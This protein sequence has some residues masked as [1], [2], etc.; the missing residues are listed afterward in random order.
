MPAP[1]FTVFTPTY[2]RRHTLPRVFAALRAQT[3]KD[4][5]WLVVDDGSQDGSA[6]LVAEFA[7][8]AALEGG[9]PVRCIVQPN[10][11]KHVA[12]NRGVREAAGELFLPLDSDDA[13][14]PDALE[15]FRHH[16]QAIPTETR[17][18]FSGICC[19]CQN[20]AGERIGPAFG[21]PWFDA[22]PTEPLARTRV[23][24]EKWGFHRTAVLRE[25]PFP[26]YPGEK[27]VPE[28]IVWDRIGLRYKLRYIDEALRIY[29]DSPDGWMAQAVSR[30]ARS[31]NA[32]ADYHL[33]R[34]QLPLPLPLR[35]KALASQVRYCLHARRWPR[36]TGRHP[37]GDA[38][39][40]LPAAALGVALWL[41]DRQALRASA[42]KLA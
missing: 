42:S 27:S 23:Q 33:Q 19:H 16:W 24:G 26:E 39:L 4:F 30:A 15:R 14:T 18:Q 41:R 10:G 5:E 13:C 40:L 21:V 9:F 28:G 37:A 36:T 32:F 38:L 3:C 8:D 12:M 20:E 11:G 7:R 22:Y 25:F 17:E 29:F 31:P 1:L 6:E 35:A 2:N 34:L